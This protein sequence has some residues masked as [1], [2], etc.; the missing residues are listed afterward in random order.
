MMVNGSHSWLSAVENI[1]LARGVAPILKLVV[2]A[3]RSNGD[4]VREPV[5]RFVERVGDRGGGR[6]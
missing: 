3:V 5:T 2:A 6:G 4:A 1:A